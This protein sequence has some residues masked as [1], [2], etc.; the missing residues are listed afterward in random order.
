MR[1]LFL[2]LVTFCCALSVLASGDIEGEIVLSAPQCDLF[3]V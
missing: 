1:C 2:F 3:L